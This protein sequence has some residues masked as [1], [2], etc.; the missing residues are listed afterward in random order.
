MRT[1][2]DHRFDPARPF[3]S[4]S[5]STGLSSEVPPQI[6]FKDLAVGSKGRRRLS[7]PPGSLGQ[8]TAAR[9]PFAPPHPVTVEATHA[10]GGLS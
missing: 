9:G 8:V 3:L 10:S 1:A 6:P 7:R 5:D 4:T 2:I